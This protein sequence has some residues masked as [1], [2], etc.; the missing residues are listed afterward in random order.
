VSAVIFK[1][2]QITALTHLLHTGR[3]AREAFYSSSFFGYRVGIASFSSNK[4]T[5]D[6]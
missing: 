4:R 3:L 1:A 6:S 2:M 5:Y